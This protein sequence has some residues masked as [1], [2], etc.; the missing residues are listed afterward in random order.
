MNIGLNRFWRAASLPSSRLCF[1]LCVSLLAT[2]CAAPPA[3]VAER[4]AAPSAAVAFDAAIDYAV[5]DL[6]VQAQRLPEFQPPVKNAVEAALNREAPPRKKIVVDASLDGVSGQQ[7]MATRFLDTRLLGRAAA[8]FPQFE[9]TTLNSRQAALAGRFLLAAT[10]TPIGETSGKTQTRF[11]VNLSLTD[12]Q[13]GYV[14]AQS[15]VQT[16]EVGVDMTPTKFYQDSPSITRDRVVE[17]HVRTAQAKAGSEADGIYVSSLTVSA[18][19]SEGSQFYDAGQFEQSLLAYEA[20]AA[21]PDGKQLRVFNG[22]YLSN[23]QLGR[24]DAAESAFARIVSLGLATNSLAVKFLFKP[25]STEFLADPKISTSYPMWLNVLAKE[26]GNAH[27]CVSVIGHSS[28]TGTENVNDRL[29]LARASAMQRRLESILPSLSSRLQPLG[30]GYR[31]NLIG[32]GTDDLRD[33]LDR[34]V[35]FRVRNCP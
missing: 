20:A 1:L 29:S 6:L 18:L 27:Q 28:R 33:S 5:D 19:I 4:P 15:A 2:S 21:R 23:M 10:V 7:T 17:G 34:R 11:R 12:L 9:V 24:S 3:A 30:M 31:E 32:T 35:E 22:L 13:T 14:L 25:G 8:R 16:T 26:M